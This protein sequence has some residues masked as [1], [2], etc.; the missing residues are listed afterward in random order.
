M[1]PKPGETV[2]TSHNDFSRPGIT[3]MPDRLL[4]LLFRVLRQN[5]GRLTKRARESDFAGLSDKEAGQIEAFYVEMRSVERPH[6]RREVPDAAR[7]MPQIGSPP[8]PGLSESFSVR[9]HPWLGWYRFGDSFKR[10]PPG[11]APTAPHLGPGRRLI[12]LLACKAL[13]ASR[14]GS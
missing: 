13:I 4:D 9:P 12:K 3:D 5:D 1:D 10:R 6:R 7:V 11:S 8:P 2:F 14:P